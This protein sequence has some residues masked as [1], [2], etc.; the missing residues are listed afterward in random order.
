MNRG[1]SFIMI[2]FISV[3]CILKTIKGNQI[4]YNTYRHHSYMSMW[5]M[6]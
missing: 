4:K 1:L 5:V 3:T 2:K 6:I